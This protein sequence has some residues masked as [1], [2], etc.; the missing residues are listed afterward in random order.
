MFTTQLRPLAKANCFWNRAAS[1][2]LLCAAPAA[3]AEPVETERPRRAVRSVDGRAAA[4]AR[5]RA[6]SAAAAR[7]AVVAGKGSQGA[8]VGATGSCCCFESCSG[9]SSGCS[10]GC[11]RSEAAACCCWVLV[12]DCS[13]ACRRP[14]DVQLLLRDCC[15]L[16]P[17]SMSVS[18]GCWGLKPVQVAQCG[19]AQCGHGVVLQDGSHAQHA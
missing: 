6:T 14:T 5:A 4:R 2:L 15:G 9:C 12:W 17:V 1:E 16:G 18:A 7:A 8:G 13:S 11:T 3:A 19:G 10:K